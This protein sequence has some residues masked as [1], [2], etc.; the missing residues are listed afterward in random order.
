MAFTLPE[1]PYAYDALEPHIDAR[2]M[3]I[4]HDQA[5]P[6]VRRQCSTRRS[7]SSPTLASTSRWRTCCRHLEPGARGHPHRRSATTA[8]DTPITRCSGRSCAGK[9]AAS[10]RGD[11]AE[12]DRQGLRRLRRTSRRSSRRRPRRASA[13]AGRGCRVKKDGTLAGRDHR[14]PGQSPLCDGMTPDP[15][16]RRLGARVL[17]QVPE[18]A[19]G[20]RRG[21]LER[22]QLG[23]SRA[24]IQ[25][26]EV[27]A[28][29]RVLSLV[30]PPPGAAGA[31]R[32]T[33]AAV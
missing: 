7:R 16:A 28:A 24:A 11:L 31:P 26:G 23:R 15:R 30:T 5:P 14:Q 33:P 8:A 18:Q 9:A 4:H 32:G 21:V 17:P 3:E 6:D 1:L 19:P 27:E 12:R 29:P 25:S 10:R 20:L 13:A 22:R 2:T